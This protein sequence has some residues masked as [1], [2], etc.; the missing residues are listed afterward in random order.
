M[1]MGMSMSPP[2]LDNG[3]EPTETWPN[4]QADPYSTN[5]SSNHPHVLCK[6]EMHL[7]TN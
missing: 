5:L 4:F 6:F 3:Y 1:S 7:R 2:K